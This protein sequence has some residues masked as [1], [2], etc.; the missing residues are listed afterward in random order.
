MSETYTNQFDCY[1]NIDIK[2][3]RLDEGYGTLLLLFYFT[4]S[5]C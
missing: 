5:I 2:P 4:A 1:R 3:S